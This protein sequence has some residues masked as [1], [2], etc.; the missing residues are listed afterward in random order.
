MSLQDLDLL[1]K[2]ANKATAGGQNLDMW[3]QGEGKK[4]LHSWAQRAQS[5]GATS[6][7][8]TPRAPV[9]VPNV[10]SWGG[11]V[12]TGV[13]PAGVGGVGGATTHQVAYTGGPNP[14][15]PGYWDPQVL[16]QAF[17]MNLGIREAIGQNNLPK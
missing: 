9:G 13:W 1:I 15:I 8:P 3:L 10:V 6:S 2:S 5:S 17:A 11:H 12:P 16:A 4:V 7:Q 14:S